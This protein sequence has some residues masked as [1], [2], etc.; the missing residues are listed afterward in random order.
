MKFCETG[1]SITVTPNGQTSV[2]KR[3]QGLPA[4][5][6]S[7]DTRKTKCDRACGSR[8]CEKE[9]FPPWWLGGEIST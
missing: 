4:S 9:H 5:R 6:L 3:L 2:A 1:R 8:F 7:N